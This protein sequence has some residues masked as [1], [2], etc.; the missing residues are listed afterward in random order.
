MIT[1]KEYLIGIEKYNKFLFFIS[2]GI[3]FVISIFIVILMLVPIIGK[4]SDILET[5]I[6]PFLFIIIVIILK[7][8]YFIFAVLQAIEAFKESEKKD[9]SMYK[10]FSILSFIA[11]PTISPIIIFF[12]LRSDLKKLDEK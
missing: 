6:T 4:N 3:V 10:V 12:L 8:P 9:T 2:I 1:E 11:L 5:N 7:I